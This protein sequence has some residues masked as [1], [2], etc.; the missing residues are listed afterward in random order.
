MLYRLLLLFALVVFYSGCASSGVIT[1]FGGTETKVTSAQMSTGDSFEILSAGT[2]LKIPISKVRS[3][4]LQ[5]NET[6]VFNGKHFLLAEIIYQD[7]SKLG[8]LNTNS[9]TPK[10]WVRSDLFIMGKS[11]KGTYKALMGNVS[12]INFT[13]Q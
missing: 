5:Q 10:A 13:I 4:R 3:I 7:A 2:V 6:K 11:D 9:S 8:T 12:K 1:D